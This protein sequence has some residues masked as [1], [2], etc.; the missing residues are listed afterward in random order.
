MRKAFILGVV[1]QIGLA[2]FLF[3]SHAQPVAQ[4]PTRGD[5]LAAKLRAVEPELAAAFA[6]MKEK[7]EGGDAAEPMRGP[8]ADIVEGA[9][10]AVAVAAAR[11]GFGRIVVS[12]TEAP[13]ILVNLV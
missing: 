13:I 4:P 1:G 3:T 10:A 6:A 2:I 12:E 5:L 8:A 7:A 11:L 9:E